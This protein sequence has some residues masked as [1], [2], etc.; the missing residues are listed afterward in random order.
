MNRFELRLAGALL[1]AGALAGC[2]DGGNDGRDVTAALSRVLSTEG[3]L[4][5]TLGD[6]VRISDGVRDFYRARGQQAV[7]LNGDELSDQGTEVYRALAESGTDG[8]PPELYRFPA[9]QSILGR[10]ANAD[11]ADQELADGERRQLLAELDL[12]LSEGMARYAQDL[13]QGTLDPKESGLDWQI[14]R[15]T[16]PQESVLESIAT[17]RPVA[18][19]VTTLRPRSPQYARF[20]QAMERYRQAAKRGGWAQLPRG[21]DVAPGETAPG[22]VLLRQR[23]LL[24][25]DQ[26]EAQLARAGEARPDHFDE[27]LVEAVK[28][29]QAR[30]SIDAD[31]RLGATTLRELNH[32]IEERITELQLTMDRWRWLPHDMGESFLMVNVAGFEMEVVQ[33]GQVVERMDVV[34]GQQNWKTPIFADTMEYLVVNPYWNVPPSILEDEIVPALDRD[35]NYLARNDM[36]RT[37]DGGVRQRPGPKNALGRFKF[38]F[39]NH[40][41]IY[42]H[43][44][45]ADHLFARSRRDFSHGCIRLERP[46]DLAELLM[47]TA[48]KRSPAELDGLLENFDEQWIKLDQKLPVYILYFT[49]WVEEDG[50][51]RFHHDVYGRDEQLEQ[52][53]EQKLT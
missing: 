32:T 15:E 38:M 3:A 27:Q 26:R 49:A 51:V 1:I 5:L 11:T 19:V 21:L 7:W 44:T 39:P 43:D 52:Q 53:A 14:P 4:T 31:G 42:L 8:L 33:G 6:T 47:R 18:E 12:L 40:D 41:N 25:P 46:R 24:G 48:T 17:G 22:V 30:H 13:A 23:F 34:V 45:P 28:H 35:P 10:F 50:T 29:F 2:R 37:S 9:A 20:M 36:E 16:A